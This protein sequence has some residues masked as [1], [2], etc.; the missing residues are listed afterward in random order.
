M[1][2]VT[3]NFFP[4]LHNPFIKPLQNLLKTASKIAIS[5]RKRADLPG[6][7][8]ELLSDN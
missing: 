4:L 1:Q 6:S 8:T 2:P 3:K 7:P 5:L